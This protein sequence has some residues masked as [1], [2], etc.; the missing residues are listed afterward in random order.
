MTF[1][2]PRKNSDLS[3]HPP[4]E[5]PLSSQELADLRAFLKTL[6]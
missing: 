3:K 1:L 6:R 5:K 2:V 4:F